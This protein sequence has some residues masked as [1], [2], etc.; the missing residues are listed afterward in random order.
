MAQRSSSAAPVAPSRQRL[1]SL[2][3]SQPHQQRQSPVAYSRSASTS[4]VMTIIANNNKPPPVPR[5][6]LIRSQQQQQV[7]I[8]VLLSRDFFNL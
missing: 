4:D 8:Q 3:T 6:S 1:R 7:K 2:S 5:N